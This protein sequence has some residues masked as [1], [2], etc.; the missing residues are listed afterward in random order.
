MGGRRGATVA[1]L[2]PTTILLLCL[3]VAPLAGGAASHGHPAPAGGPFSRPGSVAPAVQD[4]RLSG[5]SQEL[6]VTSADPAG[7]PNT[8]FETNLTMFDLTSLPAASAFQ[9]SSFDVLGRYVAVFGVFA[10]TTIP[11]IAFFSIYTNN[12]D[13]R[14]LLEYWPGL[15]LDPG[16]GYCFALTHT[17][18]GH[19]EF[20]VNGE[21]FGF[22]APNATFDF[23]VPSGNWSRGIGFTELSEWSNEPFLAPEVTATL[24]LAEFTGAGWY[25]PRPANATTSGASVEPWGLAGTL[26]R[27]AL[28]PGEIESGPKEASLPNGTALWESGPVPV[29]LRMTLNNTALPASGGTYANLLVDDTSGVPL[30]GVWIS[31]SDSA[32]GR[33]YPPLTETDPNGSARAVFVAPNGSVA[34]LDRISAVVSILGFVGSAAVNVSV[35]AAVHVEL[36]APAVVKAAAAGQVAVTLRLLDVNGTPLPGVG[37]SF[38]LSGP[39]GLVPPAAISDLNGTVETT[40]LAP[41]TP[42]VVELMARVVAPG[43]WGFA[44]TTVEVVNAAAPSGPSP[45]T[46][47]GVGLGLAAVFAALAYAEYRARERHP[48]RPLPPF[49]RRSAPPAPPAPAPPPGER[50]DQP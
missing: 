6:V 14:L 7:V 50:R 12:S 35:A 33:F 48:Y 43:F 34:L 15:A 36:E 46:N 4:P 26:Q 18:G 13:T 44:V 27:P 42:E 1:V 25:L 45:W 19:W 22:A 20:T 16:V 9:V 31:L 5:G 38:N 10:N 41:G 23:G 40:V 32:G 37:V 17:T 2:W 29:E 30:D 3:P 8:G 28:A 21:P 24:A 47:L 11:P 39:G 49:R